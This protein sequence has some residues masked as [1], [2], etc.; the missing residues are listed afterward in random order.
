VQLL[1]RA[2]SGTVWSPGRI[3]ATKKR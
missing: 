3:A 2:T 1:I